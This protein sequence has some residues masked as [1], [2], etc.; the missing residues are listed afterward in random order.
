M[1]DGGLNRGVA[2]LLVLDHCRMQTRAIAK[3]RTLIPQTSPM[4]NYSK[5][6]GK[7]LFQEVEGL[8]SKTHRRWRRGVQNERLSSEQKEMPTPV[9]HKGDREQKAGQKVS[10][11]LIYGRVVTRI[12]D[13]AHKDNG[14][15]QS[16]L[17]SVTHR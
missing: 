13:A 15:S 3:C 12:A 1:G 17:C 9:R 4:A 10:K 16:C 7:S 14:G 2:T 11:N 5:R 6:V 8:I